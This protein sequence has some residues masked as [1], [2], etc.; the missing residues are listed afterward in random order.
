MAITGI[1]PVID[2]DRRFSVW[3]DKDIYTDTVGSTGRYVPNPGDL[4][5]AYDSGWLR[6]TH[7][8]MET[9]YSTLVPWSFNNISDNTAGVVDT[10]I[11]GS[12]TTNDSYRIYVNT[13]KVPYEFSFDTRLKI[14]GSSA[15]YVKIFK[16]GQ[17]EGSSISA[18][19][20]TAGAM[21]TE[22]IQLENVVIPN[23]TVVA[24]KVPKQGNLTDKLENGEVVNV[25]VYSNSG[26]VLAIFK[27]VAVTTN[28][29]RTID[30]G[31]RLITNIS[32]IS[33][34]LSAGDDRLI[35]YPSNMT[36]DTSSL[37]G[38]VTYNDGSTQRYPVDGRKFKM[39]GL[40]NYVTTQIGQTVPLV[41]SYTLASD[42]YSNTVQEVAGTRFITKSYQL[43]TVDS[44]NLYS[45]KLF[46]VPY[47]NGADNTWRLDYY[48][49]SLDRDKI[50][51]VTNYIEYGSNSMAYS[52]AAAKWGVAQELTVSI[53]L[54][55]LGS[56]FKYYRHVQDFT[57]TLHQAGSN[58]T[59]SGYYTIEYD[60]NSIFGQI[61]Y[62]NVTP[63]GS[64]GSGV[65]IDFSNNRTVTDHWLEAAYRSTEPLYFPFG[66]AS[67]PT[68]THVKIL[69]GTSWSREVPVSDMLLPI[70]NITTSVPQGTLIRLEFI[71]NYNAK[72]LQLATVGLVAKVL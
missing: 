61:T 71:A 64:G 5:V 18:I 16:D 48:L 19:F 53:N 31:K 36:L 3:L 20:N 35:Q 66:E 47:W 38:R 58:S 1:V 29:V 15:S 52:G 8:D 34:Y 28:F 40:D 21:V 45:V 2:S 57:I 37:V 56:S 68:P 42:E 55:K 7:S 46:V 44:D 12:S 27:T 32:L 9:G 10:V 11:G 22:N 72:R 33:P 41:L 67:A 43:N 13:K 59:S 25:V 17:T 63:A 24:I 51:K 70:K 50:Y 26:S 65:T 54:D 60:A 23:T 4:V 49:Y 62:A 14:Y 69:I 39:L 6:C 30:A